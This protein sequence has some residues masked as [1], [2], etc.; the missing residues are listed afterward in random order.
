MG[1]LHFVVALHDS[2]AGALKGIMSGSGAAGFLARSIPAGEE[3][4]YP[5]AVEGAFGIPFLETAM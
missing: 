3:E 4:A 1:Q 2:G 5:N